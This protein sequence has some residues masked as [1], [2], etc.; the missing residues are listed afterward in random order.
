MKEYSLLRKYKKEG[1]IDSRFE[2]QLSKISLEDLISLKLEVAAKAVRGKMSGFPIYFALPEISKEAAFKWAVS[3][4]D[5]KTN[6]ARLLGISLARFN[7]IYKKLNIE[8]L[9]EKIT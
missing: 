3:V 8:K 2:T 4:C 1:V 7:K 5:T 6:A 9:F